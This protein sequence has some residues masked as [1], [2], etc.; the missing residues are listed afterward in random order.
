MS[1]NPTLVL[2]RL[3]RQRWR[4]LCITAV[5]TMHLQEGPSMTYTSWPPASAQLAADLR[6][7]RLGR[8][9]PRL[10]GRLAGVIVLAAS[11]LAD[12]RILAVNAT[13]RVRSV[14][15]VS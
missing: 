13:A 1:R 4:E 3:I 5:E 6:P 9:G 10:S 14:R 7:P 11:A 12:R 15:S 8:T 2:R